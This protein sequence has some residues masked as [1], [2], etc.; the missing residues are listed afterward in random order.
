[1]TVVA[2]PTADDAGH[3]VFAQADL[4]LSSLEELSPTWL[5]ERFAS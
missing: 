4:V 2:V 1:M 5:D 3:P